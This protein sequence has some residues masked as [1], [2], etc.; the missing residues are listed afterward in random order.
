[1]IPPLRVMGCGDADA[2][3]LGFICF[4][5][6]NPYVL[7]ANRVD[8]GFFVSL[9]FQ[10]YPPPPGTLRVCQQQPTPWAVRVRWSGP[11][12]PLSPIMVEPFSLIAM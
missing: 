8:L 1:M 12:A 3:C 10:F 4:V 11:C 5:V 9:I 6:V 2:T 7:S